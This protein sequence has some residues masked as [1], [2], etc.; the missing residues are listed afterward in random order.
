MRKIPD[1]TLRQLRADI[2][3][4]RTLVAEKRADLAE[5]E[6]SLQARLAAFDLLCPPTASDPPRSV[7]NL[8]TTDLLRV[9]EKAWLPTVEGPQ[10]TTS[11]FRDWLLQCDP[12]AK[13]DSWMRNSIGAV[14]KI[15][16]DQDVLEQTKDGSGRAPA[17]YRIV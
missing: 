5:A 17:E 2:A 6:E 16:D 12:T 4:Q 9:A 15:L 8:T 11:E 3:R 10:T 13:C 7:R 1:E 14:F